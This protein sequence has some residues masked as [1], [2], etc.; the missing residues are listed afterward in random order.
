MAIIQR[1]IV[2]D[3]LEIWIM[4]EHI[5]HAP[6]YPEE[7]CERLP[8]RPAIAPFQNRLPDAGNHAGWGRCETIE[9]GSLLS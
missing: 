2:I 5:E 8:F 3:Y 4:G 1:S 7:L 9:G 6:S